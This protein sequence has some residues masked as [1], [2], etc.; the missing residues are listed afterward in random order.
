M[1]IR[2]NPI[3]TMPSLNRWLGNTAAYAALI[4]TL[5]A[6][7]SSVRELISVSGLADATTRKLV[8]ALHRRGVLRICSWDRDRLGRPTMPVYEIDDGADAPRPPR[9]TSVQ[10]SQA[11]R[12][13]QKTKRL[14]GLPAWERQA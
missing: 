4:E 8:A 12:D 6:G 3:L 11:W 7:P 9:L 13:A 10:K 5:I 14:A 2:P 1:E